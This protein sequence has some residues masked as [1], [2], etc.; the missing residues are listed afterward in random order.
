M[1]KTYNLEKNKKSFEV[2]KNELPNIEFIHSFENFYV[3]N[4]E[5]ENHFIEDIR[6]K[7]CSLLIAKTKNNR[8]IILT[9]ENKIATSIYSKVDIIFTEL[10][11]L[12]PALT[13]NNNYFAELN[14]DFSHSYS[15]DE[16]YN[17]SGTNFVVSEIL[18]KSSI[19][20][21]EYFFLMK[22]IKIP[23]N[24]IPHYYYY[25]L[26]SNS[27]LTVFKEENIKNEVFINYLFFCFQIEKY[28]SEHIIKLLNYIEEEKIH[29]NLTKEN[30][31][32]INHF[33]LDENEM[34]IGFYKTKPFI[35]KKYLSHITE[36]L[37]I[38][39]DRKDLIPILYF[40]NINNF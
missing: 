35:I 26:E 27:I 32:F 5:N 38:Q 10:V 36:K 37:L 20:K 33:F 3:S 39:R 23:E 14:F 24:K 13:Q 9:F 19:S 17:Y 31:E 22:K 7:S 18:N 1:N 30:I 6:I 2:I 34:D 8:F 25:Y 15:F 16:H 12:Y 29:I 28:L 4:K 11:A 21:P 40:N